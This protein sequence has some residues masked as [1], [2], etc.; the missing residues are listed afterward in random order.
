MI[1]NWYNQIPYPALKTKR[2]ITKY[3]N[4]R[5]FTKGI[6]FLIFICKALI[7]LTVTENYSR[8]S[9]GQRTFFFFVKIIV[10]IKVHSFVFLNIDEENNTKQNAQPTSLIE[11][12]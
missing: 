7:E 4:W 8:I 10:Q 12:I 9:F 5:Q 3:I 11:Y 6:S 1:R 2:E